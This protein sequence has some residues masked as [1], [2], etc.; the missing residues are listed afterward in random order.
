MTAVALES[1]AGN[2]GSSHSN[3]A[4]SHYMRMAAKKRTVYLYRGNFLCYVETGQKCI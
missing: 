4:T 3:T 2:L 1:P